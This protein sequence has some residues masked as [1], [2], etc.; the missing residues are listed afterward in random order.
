MKFERVEQVGTDLHLTICVYPGICGTKQAVHEE[1]TFGLGESKGDTRTEKE[2]VESAI[3]EF[4]LTVQGKYSKSTT[5]HL[6]AEGSVV[7]GA[8]LEEPALPPPPPVPLAPPD[9]E[10]RIIGAPTV[11]ANGSVEQLVK[12]LRLGVPK[13]AYLVGL[14][15]KEGEGFVLVDKASYQADLAKVLS[16]AKEKILAEEALIAQ[17]KALIEA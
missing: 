10:L 4:G 6:M 1:A 14:T 13:R 17:A 5:E 12:I 8:V 3:I 9:F 15:R 7:P 11:Y 16:D 2:K